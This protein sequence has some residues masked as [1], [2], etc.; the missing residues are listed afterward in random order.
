MVSLEVLIQ[1]FE[2]LWPKASAEDWDRPGLAIGDLKQPVS[3]VLLSVDATHSVVDEALEIGANLLLTHHPLLLRGVSE[4][5]SQSVKGNIVSQA[6]RGSL[7]IFSAHTNSDIAAVGTARALAELFELESTLPLDPLSGHG[8]VGSLP[9]PMTLVG[10]AT[11][12]AKQLPSVAAGIK[13]A[14]S[15]EMQIQ[16]VGLAPG[17]GDGFLDAALS[18]QVDVFITSDLRHHP[19]QDFLETNSF[20][21]PVALIDISHWAAES[22]WLPMAQKELSKMHPDV[23]FILSELSTDPWDFAVMQ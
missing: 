4:L 21:K 15:P 22:V 9:E 3:K 11:K 6:I 2:K 8:L 20:A 12:I 18:K 13:V 5:H 23:S 1:S 10:F 14:G 17:A 16:K 19:S 7:A